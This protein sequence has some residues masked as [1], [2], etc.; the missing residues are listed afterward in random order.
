MSPK[1]LNKKRKDTH[2][3]LTSFEDKLKYAIDNGDAKIEKKVIGKRKGLRNVVTIGDKSY[4]YNPSKITK[5]LTSKLNK[6]TKTNKFEATHEIKRIYK[7]IRLRNALKSY[8]VKYKAEIKDYQSIFNSYLNAYSISNI[9]LEGLKGLSYLKYQY[10][11]LRAFLATNPNM[12]IL[13]VVYVIF[14]ELDEDNDVVGE[15]VHELRSRRY[16]INNTEDLQDTLNKMAADIELQIE[17]R[18]FKKSNFRVK[19]IESIVVHYD[20]YNPTRGGSYIDLPKWIAD[21]KACINIKNEDNKCFKYS[22]QCGFYKLY[23]KP[24]PE[25]VSHYTKL[26]D[27]QINWDGM[28]YPC[29]NRDI[30]RFE[31]NNKGLISINVYHEFD[32][33]GQSRIAVHRKTKVINAKHH[34]SLLKI[35]DES[36]KHHYVYIKDYDKLVGCQTNKSKYKLHHCRYCQHGFKRLNLLEKHLERGCLAVEGQSVQLPDEGDA[37]EFSNHYRAFK[38]PYVVYGDFECL[39]EQM[40]CGTKH[41]Q[42]ESYTKKY[43]NHTPTG[44]QLTVVDANKN[45][46][47]NVIYRGSDCMKMFCTKIGEIEKHIMDKLTTNTN[48]HITEEQQQEF[49]NATH[50]YLCNKEIV[51]NDKRGCKV[52]DHNH[53]TGEYRGCAHNVCNLNYNYKN[54]KIPVFFHNLKNYDAH[55]IISNAHNFEK[56]TKINVIAQNSEKFVTFGFNHLLFKDSFSFLPSSLEKLIK[57]NKYIEVEKDTFT[58]LDNWENNFKFSSENNYVKT[59]EDLHLLTEKGV[60]PYDYMDSW[61]RFTENEL[62][63]KEAFYSKLSGSHISDEDYARAKLVWNHFNIKDLGEYHDLYLQTDVLLLADVFENFKAMCVDYYGLDPAHY[64]TL[65]NFAWDAMLK[66]TEVYLEQI[67]DLD[68][69][70]M[71]ENGLRGGMCQVAHKHVKANNQYM[72]DYN[73]DIVSSYISYLD[74]NNLYGLAMSQKL[75]FKNFEWSDDIQ[76]SEH[77]LN[78]NDDY[79]EDGEDFDIDDNDDIGYILEVDLEYPK[80]LHDL[81]SD[82]PLAPENINVS[83]DMVSDFSKNI[84]KHYHE[85]KEVTDEKTKKLVLSVRDKTRYVVHIR[86]LKYYL[87]QG[88]R[89]TKVHRCLKF[90]QGRWLEPWINFNTEKR[91]QATNDFEKDLFKLM[92]NAVFGKTMEDVR[93]HMDFELVDNIKRLEKCLNSPTMKN[94][95]IIND[96]LV[97]IEKIKSVVRLNKPIY[98]GMAILDLSKLHMYRFYYDVLKDKYNDKIKLAYTDTDSFVVHVETDDLYKD[99]KEINTHMDFSDY[100]K[101]HTNYDKTNKKV[102]GKFKDEVNGK[103]ITEFIGLKPKMYAFK[104][105]D[106]KEQKKAKGVPKHIVKKEMNFNM[107]KKT[108]EENC[109]KRVQFNST[110]SYQHQLFSITCSKTGLSNYENKRYYLSNEVSYP[111]GH[112]AINQ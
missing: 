19:G 27:A 39:T 54:Y 77:V 25:R 104:V 1:A 103:I 96:K 56:K 51:T 85:G 28:K 10:E 17:T 8:A 52:R 95:H 62:P 93:S 14:E 108:L 101:E 29:G 66:K 86:N 13:I 80:E 49:E 68:M 16:E 42:N 79:D 64:Y 57:F 31:E 43:Q 106:D 99:L 37:I 44:F 38:C 90:V 71:I 109:N 65:P 88:L 4:Q 35:E 26:N 30:D 23:D 34:L 47:D 20:R 50:C 111:H 11:K 33:D 97:G 81:H 69:Y 48:M 60:Y 61:D 78:Y 105:Q 94:R 92:N 112:Y 67:H 63:P 76:K 32:F 59:T 2:N 6:L 24:H 58:T 87:Q 53:L 72:V 75:P 84:Y 89:L 98:V 7:S 36:G 12:K 46:V 40:A 82:Y 110:R 73:K 107:Y 18:Q 83:A 9:K 74:A 5:T 45:I 22:V 91:K 15:A 3:R 41:G 70:E 102:L 55:L 21:K 100:P